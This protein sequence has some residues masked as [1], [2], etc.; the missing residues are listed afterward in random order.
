MRLIGL[1]I[2]AAILALAP[3]AGEPQQAGKVYRVGWLGSTNPIVGAPFLAAFR[4]GLRE[5]GYVDV[6]VVGVNRSA[7]AAQ[8]ATTKIPIVMAAAEAF[9]RFFAAGGRL[10]TEPEMPETGI[11]VGHVRVQGVR[12]TPHRVHH[13][14]LATLPTIGLVDQILPG[15]LRVHRGVSGHREPPSPREGPRCRG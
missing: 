3:L 10:A 15:L 14:A 7:V 8:Q 2:L 13:R 11:E 1:V 4:D 12:D 6:F 5:R 9:W